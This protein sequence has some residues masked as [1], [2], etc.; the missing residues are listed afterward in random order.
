MSERLTAVTM[1][2]WG[3]AMSE[4]K[5]TAWLAANGGKVTAGE[6]LVEIETSKISNEYEAPS[7]GVLLRQVVGVGETVAVGDILGVIGAAA[8][9]ETEVDAFVAKFHAEF[10]PP[11][12]SDD[13]SGGEIY[14]TIQV[15]GR[16]VRYQQAGGGEATPL[17]LIHG[18]GGDLNN[19]LF[20]QIPLS[21]GRPVYALDL[22]GHGGSEK[23]LP[24]PAVDDLAAFVGSFL[25]ALEIERVH[26]VGHSLGG[27]IALALALAEPARIRSLTLIA[28][29]GLGPEINMAYIDGFVAAERR[30]ELK[31]VVEMLFADPAVASREMID[32]IL[33]Y[34]RLD[35]V[36]AALRQITA[37]CFGGAGQAGRLNEVTMPVQA[38]WG[39]RDA[40][41]PAAHAKA[42]ARHHLLPGAGHMVHMEAAAAVNAL[43]SDFLILAD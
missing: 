14:Q 29:A 10:V 38:I 7:S 34:K 13:G 40:I 4:G 41:I 35:G 37:A 2:K 18:F 43:I 9:A 19:W 5:L 15:D 25:R 30:K 42:V 36:T 33:A 28:P 24:G 20:N 6:P 27:A 31:P 22:P 39:E 17:L 16:L 11:P 3:L 8:A 1:P 12:P 23:S 26:L 32:E 21:A